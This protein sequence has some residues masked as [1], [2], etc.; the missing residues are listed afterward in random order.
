MLGEEDVSK[1]LYQISDSRVEADSQSFLEAGMNDAYIPRN[2]DHDVSHDFDY[3]YEALWAM[4]S[5][6]NVA[7]ASG[8]TIPT[9]GGLDWTGCI[10]W[11]EEEAPLGSGS[12]GTVYNGLWIHIENLA[13]PPPEIVVKV[14]RPQMAGNEQEKLTRMKVST[15]SC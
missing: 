3:D 9:L 12:F 15:L 4:Y 10:D 8:K 13:H 14:M 6:E 7:A 11:N 5:E 2:P 1:K